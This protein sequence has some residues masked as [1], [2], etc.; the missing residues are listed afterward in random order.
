MTRMT[1]ALVLIF[2]LAP[3][4][5]AG[6]GNFHHDLTISLFPTDHSL[7]ATDSL[8]IDQAMI[9]NHQVR[10][11][12]N[13]SLRIEEITSNANIANWYTQEDV[14]P[15]VFVANPDSEDLDLIKRAKGIFINLG[16]NAWIGKPLWIAITYS[17]V[18]YDSLKAPPK[19]YAKGF[20]NTTG[21]I[22]ERGVFLT[23]ESLWYSYIFDQTFSFDL[24]VDVP[25]DWMVVSQGERIDEQLRV[26]DGE[27][28][29][30]ARWAEPNPGPE[31][32]LIA[33]KYFRYEAYDNG[34]WLMAYLY[35]PVDSLAQAYV[36]ATGR[37][38]GMY[39]RLIGH[40]P[41]RKFAL[42]EN[43]WQTGF[44]MPSFTLL[45]SKV[46][47][48]PFI[49]RTSYGHEI[50]HNW[51]G[52]SVYVDYDSGNWCEGLTTYLADYLYKEKMGREQAR[53]YRH[54]TLIAFRNNVTAEKD[55]PLNE[56][57]ERYDAASQSI[58]Y[59]KGLMVFHMLRKSLGDSLFWECLRHFYKTYRFRI[60][61]W[62][63]I[64]RS[65]HETSG[66]DFSWFFDQWVNRKG[67]PSLRLVN[68]ASKPGASGYTLTFTLAQDE[69]IYVLDVPI[70]VVTSVGESRYMIR[71][72]S[73]ESTYTLET[74]SEP[75]ALE[76]DPDY[77]LMRKLYPEEIPTTL[78]ALFGC[79]S[80]I[81][82]VGS[83]EEAE[84][85]SRLRVV[86]DA[87]GLAK[88]TFDED[89]LDRG[90]LE[91]RSAWLVGHGKLGDS[92]LTHT[93]KPVEVKEGEVKVED[94]VFD[95]TDGT[96]IVALPSPFSP[97]FA[98]GI[99]LTSDVEALIS[100]APRI[101]H[102]SRYSFIG[103]KGKEAVLKG[104]W[105]ESKS[106]LSVTFTE[107]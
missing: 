58:G 52:N 100:L 22:D 65:A 41:Y 7:L 44:G 5:S 8:R 4:L 71:L 85:A 46:I 102:Y 53:D 3:P 28:R 14:D 23:N 98:L 33:G 31:L 26:I 45:G 36:K 68:A 83:A 94:K 87:W 51:W 62:N 73:A 59:G 12:F 75:K 74:A 88:R 101:P 42:V 97:D 57:R 2:A 40:Y 66:L 107:R 84:T 78:S 72:A 90:M 6:G 86:A 18:I 27:E 24:L 47:R 10:L 96:L 60:A 69:P 67:I 55:F 11:L 80:T 16:D 76:V 104:I 30:F 9:E 29:V 20:G 91:L 81:M 89:G 105:K 32:Y 56:F 1:A 13:K 49:I 39:E 93:G 48:L 77:D 106:P 43:F 38:L 34:T 15:A 63:D 92:I 19:A 99:I 70:R 17:G 103:F 50:L 64:A 21:L 35:A 79:D 82:V 95:L 37:Y 54:H 25:K 61:S